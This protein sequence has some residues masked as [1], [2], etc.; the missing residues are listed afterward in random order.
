M[1]R[2]HQHSFII[3]FQTGKGSECACLR[4]P[5]PYEKAAEYPTRVMRVLYS[6]SGFG[7]HKG[8]MAASTN[9][10][11]CFFLRTQQD[12]RHMQVFLY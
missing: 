3:N 10:G 9:E 7:G 6:L 12:E 11:Q 4:Q 1:C 5:S 8:T 2:T